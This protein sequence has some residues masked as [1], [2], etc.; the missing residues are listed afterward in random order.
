M[1]F[2]FN[3]LDNAKNLQKIL[4]LINFIQ[5]FIHIHVHYINNVVL[6]PK[7]LNILNIMLVIIQS[8]FNM[9]SIVKLKLE[10]LQH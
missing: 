10:M 6:Y 9:L 2:H 3:Y 1:I 8:I 5:Q 7:S 4:I